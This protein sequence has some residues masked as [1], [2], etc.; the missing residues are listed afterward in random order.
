MKRVYYYIR[1]DIF[2]N[3]LSKLDYL[4]RVIAVASAMIGVLFLL[5]FML[6]FVEGVAA[7]GFF[8]MCYA[9]MLNA[10]FVSIL[11]IYYFFAKEKRDK[12]DVL[13]SIGVMLAN[14]PLAAICAVS[15]LFLLKIFKHGW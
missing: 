13:I 10:I 12:K 14:I 9:A 15:G 7:C 8:F 4:C 11:I 5:A 3:Q 6:C 2:H 1:E